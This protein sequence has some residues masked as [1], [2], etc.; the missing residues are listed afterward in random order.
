[1]KFLRTTL[2]C[3]AAVTLASTAKAA[4]EHKNLQVLD[5][6][7]SKDAL[8]KMMEGFAAQ[9]GVKCQFCHVDELYEKDDKKQKN[10]ARKMIKLVLEMKARKPE[11]FKTTVKEAAIQCAMCHRGKPQPEAFVP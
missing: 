2:V 6:N 11:F 5:K 8:K 9:L 1:M 7:I 10:D 3:L 4:P